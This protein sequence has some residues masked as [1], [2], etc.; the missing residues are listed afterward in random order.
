M[1]V[2]C[3][4]DAYLACQGPPRH[5]HKPGRAFASEREDILAEEQGEQKTKQM[6]RGARRA[7]L[8]PKNIVFKK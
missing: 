7:A 5:L 4:A 2:K 8:A 1:F 6:P 3:L